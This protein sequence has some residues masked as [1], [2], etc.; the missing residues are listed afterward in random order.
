MPVNVFLSYDFNDNQQ[1]MSLRTLLA[2]PNHPIEFH[3]RSPQAP[4]VGRRGKPLA[5][6][7]EDPSAAPVRREIIRKFNQ[8][9]RLIVLVGEYTYQSKW[10][11]WEIVN[12]FEKKK[13]LQ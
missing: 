11:K 1:A 10:V 2:D 4:V 12:F 5:F 9:T 8:S 6:P 3:D 13:R 7:P